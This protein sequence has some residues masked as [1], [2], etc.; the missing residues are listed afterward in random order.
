MLWA[1]TKHE[2]GKSAKFDDDYLTFMLKAAPEG[3]E[4]PSGSYYMSQSGIDG[5]SY[6]LGHPLAQHILSAAA[7]RKLNGASVVFDY[8]AWPQTAVALEPLIG[9]AGTLVAHK[10]SVRGADDHD[11]IILVALTDDGALLDPKA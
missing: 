5:H 10:L 8:T 11:H 4:V 3:I 2:L 1:V 7:S 6:R 9:K